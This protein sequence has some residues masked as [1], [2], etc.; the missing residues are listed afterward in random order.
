MLGGKRKRR[1]E[2]ADD[3]FDDFGS[4]SEEDFFKEEF[5]NLEAIMQEDGEVSYYAV[6]LLY[7]YAILM[8]SAYVHALHCLSYYHCQYQC[9][10]S[11]Y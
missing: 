2:E 6:V 9:S 3:D 8:L 1:A 11:V 5:D 7:L 4:F 10:V